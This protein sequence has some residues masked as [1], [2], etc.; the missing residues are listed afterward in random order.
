VFAKVVCLCSSKWTV[1]TLPHS[2]KLCLEWKL[3]F[4]A[5]ITAKQR[6]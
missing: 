3:K 4:L 5:A 1:E 2:W 6:V